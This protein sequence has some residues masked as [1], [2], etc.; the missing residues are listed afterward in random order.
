[1]AVDPRRRMEDRKRMEWR[2]AS[3]CVVEEVGDFR[4]KLK[5]PRATCLDFWLVSQGKGTKEKKNG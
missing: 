4:E 5:R 3:H 2:S 1:M